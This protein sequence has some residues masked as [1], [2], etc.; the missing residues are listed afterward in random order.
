MTERRNATPPRTM[1]Y[2]PEAP[3]GRI[4]TGADAI[5]AAVDNGWVDTPAKL[6]KDKPVTSDGGKGKATGA[7]KRTDKQ[8]P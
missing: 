7:S 6:K 2:S 4:F 5:E 1:L 8:I 3:M